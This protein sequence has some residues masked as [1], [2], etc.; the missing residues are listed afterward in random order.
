MTIALWIIALCEIIRAVQNAFQLRMI[1]HDTGARDNAY[2]EFVKSLKT[3]D[4]EMVKNLLKEFE[5][6]DEWAE[7]EP[8][9]NGIDDDTNP[10]YE[11]SNCGAMCQKQHNYCPKCGK[12]MRW[13][14]RD[15]SDDNG[16]DHET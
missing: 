15:N 14:W 2:A 1:H 8:V 4:R 9:E 10:A 6:Q 11:C 16:L 3:D 7:W 13:V 12:K 5:Q